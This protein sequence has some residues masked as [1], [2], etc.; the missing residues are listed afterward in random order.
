M[1]VLRELLATDFIRVGEMQS[2]T[3]GL[4]YWKGSWPDLIDR[5]EAV[6]NIQRPPGMGEGPW[7]FA[8]AKGKGVARE[9]GAG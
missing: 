7:F 2:D 3:A 1:A 8:T 5:V 4:S 9:R 6:W